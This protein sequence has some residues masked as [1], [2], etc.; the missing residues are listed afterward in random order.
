MR[1]LC[2]MTVSA[3]AAAEITEPRASADISAL[4]PAGIDRSCRWPVL[5]LFAAAALWLGIGAVFGVI[6]AIKAHA[7]G[8]L[9]GFAWLTYGRVRPA[10]TH[11]LLYGFVL[12]AGLGIAL[13]M[14]C[15]LGKNPLRGARIISAAAFF[16]NVGLL[17][18]WVGI[19][20]GAS[21]GYPWLEMPRGAAPI[22]FFSWVLA[23]IWALINLH[24][25]QVRPLYVSQWFLL[26]ALLWFPWVYSTAELLLNWFRVRGVLQAVV[27]GWYIHNFYTLCAGGLGL[28]VIFYFLP[29]LAGRPLHSRGL[30]L[31]GFWLWILFG[32]WGGARAGEPVPS[33]ISSVS[34]VAQ[35]F[36]LIPVAAF[37]MS[38]FRTLP[39]AWTWVKR[40]L[41]LR[42]IVVGACSFLL[43]ALLEAAASHPEISSV[44]LFTLYGE[45][46]TQ[47]KVHG[48]LAMALSGALYYIAPRLAGFDWRSA[49][50]IRFHFWTAAAGTL[51]IAL[52][53]VIGGLVQGTGINRPETEFLQVVRRTLPFL[54]M[55]TLGATLLCAGYLALL[56]NLGRLLAAACPCGEIFASLR[57]LRTKAATADEGR[58]GK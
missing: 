15:R 31:F 49:G 34:T 36:L 50:W 5:L 7:P 3:L 51:L 41:A 30:A 57:R 39:D 58:A 43:A 45:G 10:G 35:M 16:W 4:T 23:G 47:L 33:W 22:L 2:I 32:G 55:T 40:S 13:W 26:A 9:A 37:A 19:L 8:F 44:T 48:F 21:T 42:F 53:L 54:G 52:C 28:A 38:W 1:P 11:A 18:G 27:N 20:A 25:R 12:Q 17:I 24:E 46:V 14:F 6:T 56:L 29:K